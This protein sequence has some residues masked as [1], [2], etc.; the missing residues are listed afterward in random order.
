MLQYHAGTKLLRVGHLESIDRGYNILRF[1]FECPAKERYAMLR[2]KSVRVYN[3]VRDG[4]CGFAKHVGNDSIKGNIANGEHILIAVF[5]T[6]FTGHQLEAI[7]CKF[8]EDTG[9]LVGDK[10]TGNQAETKQ[11]A[12]P[13]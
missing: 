10:A 9:I 8:P 11:V 12:D 13:F 6:G 7:P 2:V 1:L 5:L 3:V 4:R